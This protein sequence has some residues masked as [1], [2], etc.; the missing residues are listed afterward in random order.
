MQTIPTSI[1]RFPTLLGSHL[2]LRNLQ[3]TQSSLLRT[4]VQL[5]TG[6]AVNRPSDDAMS[7][8][9]ILG[10]D[11][12]ISQRMRHIGNL[13]FADS[14][15]SVVDSTI[16]EL[17]DL[18]LEVK[19][20]ASG[21]LGSGQE[22]SSAQAD[23][24]AIDALLSRIVSLA[25]RSH[26][27]LHL[28]GGT[29]TG[30]AP[31]IDFAGG[32]RY[33]GIGEGMLTDLG[34][35]NE[36]PLTMTGQDVFGS[37]SNRIQGAVDFTPNLTGQ[38]LLEDLDGARGLGFEPGMLS[39]TMTPPGIA[40][41]VDLTDAHDMDD[42]IAALE[43]QVPGVF[44]I[45]ARGLVVDVPVGVS[46]TIEG[47]DTATD[48][49]LQ[50]TW[51]NAGLNIAASLNARLTE[52]STVQSLGLNLG[53]MRIENIGQQHDIDLSTAETIGDVMRMIDDLDIGVRMEI[54]DSG[55][56]LTMLNEVSGSSMSIGEVGGGS[57]ATQLGIRSMQRSTLL[58]DFND[59][60]G[61]DTVE[62]LADLR[63]TLHDGSSFEVDLTGAVDVG[64][65][66]D[67][68]DAAA[69]AAFGDPPPVTIGMAADGNGIELVDG[70]T[71]SGRL[72]IESRNGSLA[73]EQ[74]GLL[75]STDGLT[76]TGED[77]S[78][79]AV[80][81][82]FSHLMDLRS[83]MLSGDEGAVSRLVQ[84]LE[85]DIER[86]AGARAQA[87]HRSRMVSDAMARFESRNIDDETLRS[88]LRDVDF[89][90][91]SMRFAALQ[92]Q[93]QAS[94]ATTARLSSLSLMDFLG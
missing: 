51:D 50:G 31:L 12:I 17:S 54:S 5:A 83:A 86:A 53:T 9:S 36:I 23:A 90:D 82:V 58:A 48:L 57:T 94:L 92:Q 75:G 88:Q 69:R 79:V 2:M 40:L 55:N 21:H 70:T 85:E 73:P 61:V 65:V 41:E 15:L 81:S 93:L 30:R 64:T 52:H 32:Y 46:I 42:V 7:A 60:Y 16:G 27:D 13:Q 56:T 29:S 37:L 84:K 8:R 77:R 6:R 87:G 10:L 33:R 67:A 89:T 63:I 47:G 28:F 59:G 3:A 76:Y 35:L 34:L 1:G 25:N 71:G 19:S 62:G 38:T 20:I 72:V 24:A 4:Q 22:E 91:A 74:L 14:T 44:S 45:G 66:I 49:G 68:I 39:I 26:N 78:R 80:E 11:S 43:E 18:L